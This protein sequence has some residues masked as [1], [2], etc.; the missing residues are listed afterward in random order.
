[1]AASLLAFA[2]E[3]GVGLIVAGQSRRPSWRRLFRASV[4]DRLVHNHSGL[5]VLV[6]P[7]APL[8]LDR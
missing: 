4:V 7:F 1:V 2:S 5:D 3:R 8:D 6:V